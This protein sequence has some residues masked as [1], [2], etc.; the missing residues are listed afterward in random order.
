VND[1]SLPV[2]PESTSERGRIEITHDDLSTPE[3][4]QQVRSLREAANPPLVR[5]VGAPTPPEASAWWRGG[6]ASMA[7][8]GIIGGAV[9]WA[10]SE[11][12]MGGDNEDRFFSD[13]PT[14][15]TAVWMTLVA[16][17]LA[18]LLTAWDGI[19]ARNGSKVLESWKVGLPVTAIGGFI[20]G[21]IGQQIYNPFFDRALERA[22]TAATEREAME[23]LE[24]ALRVPRAIGFLVAGAV[25][26][27]A[28]GVASGSK[29]RAINGAIGGAIGGFAG[30][31]LF[32]F[33]QSSGG[34]ARFVALSVT[35]VAVG[36]AIGLVEQVRKEIWLEIVNGGMGGK[37][38][39]LYHDTTTL[40]ASP[41]CHVTLIKD[42]HLVGHHAN[43]VRGRTGPEIHAIDPNAPVLVNGQPVQ[44]APLVSGDQIQIGTTI[45][46]LGLREQ[47][48]PTV[49]GMPPR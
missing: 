31:L 43:I 4:E 37:Q 15:G 7:L 8:A 47:A 16:L 23:I 3:V 10:L 25:V 35:G 14:M 36:A 49:A 21:V 46:R 41:G 39:I 9:G 32:S 5:P 19:E 28:L 27:I 13:D 38:F 40:G 34:M 6:V 29:Q 44:Q 26:G 30:G 22:F 45:L 11:G 24:S 20:G 1:D 2:N 12:V 48:T 18:A 17:G 33:V 42:P